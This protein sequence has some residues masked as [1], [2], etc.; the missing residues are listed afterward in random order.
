MRLTLAPPLL[1]V[2]L[3]AC[4]LSSTAEPPP[5]AP[6]EAAAVVVPAEPAPTEPPPKPSAVARSL[7]PSSPTRPGPTAELADIIRGPGQYRDKHVT[8]QARI[9]AV[10]GTSAFVL[11]AHPKNPEGT[12]NELLVISRSPVPGGPVD[13]LWLEHEVTATGRVGTWSAEELEQ[14]LGLDLDPS[15]EFEVEHVNA[16]LI[17]DQVDRKPS[18]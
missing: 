1:L 12:G 13:M 2:E 9:G 4:G 11:A 3:V 5:P 15:L 18:E 8:V 14:E 6:T 10:V 7:G 16:V 17:A